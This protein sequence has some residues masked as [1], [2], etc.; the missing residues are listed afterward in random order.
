MSEEQKKLL[1]NLAKGRK[2]SKESRKKMSISQTGRKHPEEVKEKISLAHKEY[3]KKKGRKTN[4]PLIHNQSEMTILKN[5]HMGHWTGK[6][7]DTKKEGFIYCIYS[8]KLGFYVGKKN[9]RVKGHSDD[10][11]KIYTGSSKYLNDC[12][13]TNGKHHFQ[14]IILES[15]DTKQGLAAAEAWTQMVLK[16]PFREKAFNRYIEKVRGKVEE[17]ITA[18]HMRAVDMLERRIQNG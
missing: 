10:K 7:P 13:R 14:F 1:S 17:E 16:T 11:W 12:I 18:D 6:V 2:H 8:E 15:Y 4:P 3:A 5:S 9:F